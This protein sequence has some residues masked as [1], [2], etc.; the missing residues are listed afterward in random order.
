MVPFA[1]GGM[2]GFAI[3]GLVLLLNRDTLAANGH[4]NWLWICLA[5]FLL[6][7][8]GLATM[9]VHDRNRRRRRE[10]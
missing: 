3:A 4:E 10:G 8:P 1:L 6:G 9:I 5:G 7:F 2:L